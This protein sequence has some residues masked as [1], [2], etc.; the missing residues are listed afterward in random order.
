MRT[1]SEL[2][3]NSHKSA[4][5]AHKTYIPLFSLMPKS[6]LGMKTYLG[7]QQTPEFEFWGECFQPS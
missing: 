5:M 1:A 7:I 2:R 3:S 4:G 6:T